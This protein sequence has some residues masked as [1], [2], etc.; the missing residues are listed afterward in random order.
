MKKPHPKYPLESC[1]K[2]VIFHSGTPIIDLYKSGYGYLKF[3]LDGMELYAHRIVCGCW[4]PNP[5][6][7]LWTQV[8]HIDGN[9]LNNTPENLEWVSQSMNMIHSRRVNKDISYGRVLSPQDYL[10][11]V[12]LFYGHG[13][14]QEVISEMFP[15]GHRQI[16]NI[17]CGQRGTDI[18]KHS[19]HWPLIL[20]RIKS[21][22][23]RSG[24]SYNLFNQK[25][26]KS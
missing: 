18:T 7:D 23:K 25:E 9:R 16:N 26:I 15:V 12:N 8:N 13:L 4:N 14:S 24:N 21:R 1:E 20:E 6:P 10:D 3:R 17:C 19:Q 5:Y 11:I 2:G 22:K